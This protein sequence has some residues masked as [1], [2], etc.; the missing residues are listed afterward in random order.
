MRPQIRLEGHTVYLG[1]MWTAATLE[2]TFAETQRQLPPDGV[3]T[4]D[5]SSVVKLDTSGAWF[6]DR[7]LRTLHQAGREVHLVNMSMGARS[8]LSMVGEQPDPR[9]IKL[10]RPHFTF[11][12]RTGHAT[13]KVGDNAVDY[14]AFLGETVY[15]WSQVFTQ[16]R[17]WRLPMLFTHIEQTGVNAVPIIGLLSFLIGV[18]IAYQGL[19]LLQDYGATALVAKLSGL[20]ILRELGPLIAAIVVAGRTGSAFTAEIG[21][22]RVSEEIDAIVA[23]GLSPAEMLVLPRIFG[24]L[25]AL[26]LLTVLAD[27]A[28]LV[29]AGL[30][31]HLV[32]GIAPRAFADELVQGVSAATLLTGLAKAPVFAIVI[33]SLGCFHGFRAENNAESV[34]RRTTRSVV[35]SIFLVIVIDAVFSIAYSMLHL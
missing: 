17:H 22:M 26:P 33:A 25:I 16:R 7:A 14:L 21:A 32:G 10:K 4:V 3:L 1:G 9:A 27:A 2:K 24:L 8:L 11:L 15:H 5:F 30:T 19:Y 6:I 28:G 13:L 34:G 20:T 18:V 29:G 23:M 35:Q 12:Q 31:A